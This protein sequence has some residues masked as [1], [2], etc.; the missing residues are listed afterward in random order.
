LEWLSDT[1]QQKEARVEGGERA[2]PGVEHKWCEQRWRRQ[3]SLDPDTKV[4][5]RG[6]D[7]LHHSSIEL[8]W[9]G[10]EVERSWRKIERR[11]RWRAADALRERIGNLT[12][13]ML[14]AKCIS[15]VCEIEQLRLRSDGRVS[16]N[17]T[18][19]GRWIPSRPDY[20]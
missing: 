9:G 20:Y 4:V 5:A 16:A 11:L 7:A 13:F 12:S 10:G 17:W 2:P 6:G 18:Q 3:G 8:W 19:S 1:L 15:T 14:D